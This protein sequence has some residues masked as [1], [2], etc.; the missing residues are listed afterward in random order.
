[1]KLAFSA[2]PDKWGKGSWQLTQKK[3][4]SKLKHT[5]KKDQKKSKH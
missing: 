3:E 2:I 1:M 5:Q 4:K